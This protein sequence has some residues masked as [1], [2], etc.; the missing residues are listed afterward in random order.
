MD[1]LT[2]VLRVFLGTLFLSTGMSKWKNMQEHSV[3]VKEYRILPAS[4]IHLFVRAETAVELLAGVLLFL[5]LFQTFG[6]SL[7]VLLLILYSFAI[8]LNLF[9]G[10]REISCGCGG[11]AGNHRISWLLVVRNL[12]LMLL[13]GWVFFSPSQWGSIESLWI[14]EVSRLFNLS[15][16]QNVLMAWVAL[17]FLAMINGVWEIYVKVRLFLRRQ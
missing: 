8:A 11:V 13:A 1:E 5:G 12:L 10:R 2:F 15:V 7:A 4:S 6:A 17:L 9:R 14:G 16:I 3:I